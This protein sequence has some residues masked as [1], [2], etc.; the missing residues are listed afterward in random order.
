MPRSCGQSENKNNEPERK[1]QMDVPIIIPL[2]IVVGSSVWVYFDA[3]R[4]GVRKTGEPPRSL[5]LDTGPAGWAAY[6]LVFWI[7]GFPMYLSDRAGFKRKFGLADVRS[8]PAPP[9]V[10]ATKQPL[11]FEQQLRKLA[12]LKEDGIISADEFDQKKKL[13]LGL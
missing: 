13:L 7:L 1:P 11:D 3:K 10:T 2:L 5:H 9:P 4:I 6:C 8:T 12:K